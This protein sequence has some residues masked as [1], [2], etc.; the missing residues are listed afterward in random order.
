LER[1]TKEAARFDRKGIHSVWHDIRDRLQA[2]ADKYATERGVFKFSLLYLF[3]LFAALLFEATP[4]ADTIAAAL[5]W[6]F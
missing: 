6:G 2:E 1:A 4:L 5:G 3:A